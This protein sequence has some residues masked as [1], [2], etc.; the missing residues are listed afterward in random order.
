ME[1]SYEQERCSHIVK[2]IKRYYWSVQSEEMEKLCV[3]LR[4]AARE[5][6]LYSG[7]PNEDDEHVKGVGQIMSRVVADSLPE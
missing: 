2:E 7:N 3:W 6:I 4:N 5:T 1:C